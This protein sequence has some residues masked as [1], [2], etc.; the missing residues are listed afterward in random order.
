MNLTFTSAALGDMTGVTLPSAFLA[1]TY[2]PNSP[3]YNLAGGVTIVMLTLFL[4]G[5]LATKAEPALNVLG[6][7]VE[8]LSGG[9]FTKKMLIWGVC[10]GVATGMCAGACKILFQLPLIY[11]ILVKYVVACGLTVIAR[12]SITAVAWDSAG[13]QAP[14]SGAGLDAGV[15]THVNANVT[16]GKERRAA[17]VTVTVRR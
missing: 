1:V 14:G 10:A 3:Y 9:K 5:I 6:E 8:T 17:H 2:D 12:E 13:G 16:G 11:F 4:L 15:L 7:T